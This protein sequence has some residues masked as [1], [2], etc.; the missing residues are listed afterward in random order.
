MERPL[1]NPFPEP[2]AVEFSVAGQAYS[3]L[4]FEG[5]HLHTTLRQGLMWERHI[6]FFMA[7]R[8]W[9]PD[10]VFF[11]IGANVGYYSLLATRFVTD[12]RIVA[13]E[14]HPAIHAALARN[15]SHAPAER[16]TTV[17]AA[18][19]GDA[20]PTTSIVFDP[21]ESGASHVAEGGLEVDAVTIDALSERFGLPDVVKMDIEG[22][23]WDAL[24]GAERT[25]RDGAPRAVMEFAPGNAH[26]SWRSFAEALRLADALGYE[27]RFF[28]GHTG[29]AV[30]PISVDLLIGLADYWLAEETG[31]HMDILMQRRNRTA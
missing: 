27:F 24:F 11:D 17:H 18:I 4:C 29:F 12:G 31:G 5:D 20:T 3:M 25:L 28:R 19:V 2:V 7:L 22:L 30:E 21:Q 26:R 23:E 13:V 15:L 10:S 9:K 6:T 1:S 16:C 14:P 8:A